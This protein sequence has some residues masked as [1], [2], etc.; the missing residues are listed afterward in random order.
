MF[1]GTNKCLNWAII[2]CGDVTEVKSGPGLYKSKHSNLLGVYNR[3]YSKAN[4][5]AIRHKVANVYKDIEDLFTDSNIDAVYI[6]TP[7]NTHFK[8][9]IMALNAGKIPYIEKPFVLDFSE[10]KAIKELS[11]E[12]NIMPYVAFYRRGL[13]K[14]IKIKE[15]IDSGII[16]EIRVVNITQFMMVDEEEKNENTRPWRVIPE[17]SGG[18]KF[19]DVG[20]HVLDCLIWFFGEME[21]MD[22]IITNRGKFYNTDDTV[23]TTFKFKN[24]I[25]GTGTWCF[26]ADRHFNEVQIVG[27]KGNITY[28]G[29]S[30]KNLYLTTNNKT[31]ELKFNVPEHISMPYQQ[32]VINEI[33]G[34]NKSNAKFRDSINLVKMCE[35]LYRN[36]KLKSEEELING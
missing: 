1:E 13:D 36:T 18:G 29:L 16:G 33:L 7:P 14:F 23:M 17:I 5:F 27:S 22:G 3:T 25:V 28:D 6:A 30:C 26:V 35:M 9:T 8:Y 21:F 11:I 32:S 15:I 20:T 4:D 10:A 12:K 34:I 24:G 2:G 19:L 31:I